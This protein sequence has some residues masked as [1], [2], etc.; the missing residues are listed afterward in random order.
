MSSELV[1]I[2]NRGLDLTSKEVL[3]VIRATIA[4]EA[5]DAEFAMFIEFCKGTG[6]NPHKKEVWFIKTKGYFSKKHNKQIEG[7]VQI[8]TGINGFYAIANS[9]PQ[10]DGMEETTLERDEK[11]NI[12]RAVAKVWRKDRRFPSVGT[13]EWKE[14]F[15]GVTDFKN[16]IWETKPSVMIAKV[17]ESIALRKAFPN[18]LNGLYTQEEMPPEYSNPVNVTPKEE[19]PKSVY[20]ATMYRITEEQFNELGENGYALYQYMDRNANRQPNPEYWIST[21]PLKKAERFIVPFTED[22]LIEKQI[23]ESKKLSDDSLDDF[24]KALESQDEQQQGA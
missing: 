13:A 18:E 17:A 19:K 24:Y 12:L 3:N 8:M 5:T 6:L 4:P 16:S 10:Y 23:E 14:Y 1:K 7:K 20:Q 22:S 21:H 15:P 2:T 11:G 9:H